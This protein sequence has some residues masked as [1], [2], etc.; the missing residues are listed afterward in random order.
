MINYI[1]SLLGGSRKSPTGYFRFN[2]HGSWPTSWF[3][4]DRTEPAP[5]QFGAVF[6]CVQIISQEIAKLPIHH[7]RQLPN[8][9][10]EIVTNSAASRV[11][12]RPNNY[13]SRSD[14]WLYLINSLLY[15]GNGYALVERNE[16]REVSG[17]YP[18]PPSQA[19]PHVDPTTK[20]VFYRIGADSQ[21]II[22]PQNIGSA[23]PQRNV[24]HL[25]TYTPRHPLAGE[26]PITA[27]RASATLGQHIEQNGA[28]F[29]KNMSRPSGVLRV[30]GKL[31]REARK[32]LRES[33]QEST[34]REN[35]GNI[36]VLS[37]GA[38][39]QQITMS[40][41][42]ADIVQQHK[43]TIE[44]VARVFRVPLFMLGDMEKTTFS[45]VET[46]NRV[47]YSGA[48]SFYLEHIEAALNILFNVKPN[49]YIQFDF[50][51]NLRT[52]YKERIEATTI[53][54][55]GGLFTINEARAKEN[56]PAV[57]GG[58]NVFIQQQMQTVKDRAENVPLDGQASEPTS[59]E[60][61]A[62]ED[63]AKIVAM[64]IE[65][66]IKNELD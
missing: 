22:T 8:G 58:E 55:K 43:M 17:L 18:I 47:F 40:A 46:L 13:Q 16:R 30:P 20:D 42:D 31:G 29:F 36:G 32:R 11:L 38:E 53:G 35:Q 23:V 28:Y 65:K 50:E 66:A 33:W 34:K 39:W 14:F 27:A 57:D 52:T 41:Q 7:Y 4:L 63:T 21:D 6:S 26:T 12:N 3:Q 64:A 60:P 44:D 37:D 1:K 19:W 15:E 49:E 51:A 48:L 56:L 25:R 9:A 54:T 24:L 61:I 59:N 5:D 10:R 2:G 62:D 45:N